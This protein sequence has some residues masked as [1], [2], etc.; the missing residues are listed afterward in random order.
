M[1]GAIGG[2][3]KTDFSWGLVIKGDGRVFGVVWPFGYEARRDT[4]GVV[5]VDRDGHRLAR[6]GDSI[7]MAGTIDHESGVMHPCDPPNLRVLATAPP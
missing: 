1:L 3:L 7:V 5:L 6:E 4:D 2:V